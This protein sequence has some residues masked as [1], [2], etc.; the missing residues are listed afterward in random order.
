MGRMSGSAR[1]WRAVSARVHRVVP[2]ADDAARVVLDAVR[3]A[4]KASDT[5]PTTLKGPRTRP[6]ADL[7]TPDPRRTR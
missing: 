4:S 5:G 3:R 1:P 6:L 2:E 7:T